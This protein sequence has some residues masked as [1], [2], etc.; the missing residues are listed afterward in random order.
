M[1]LRSNQLPT[2][3]RSPGLDAVDNPPATFRY[4]SIK[5]SL[6][7]SSLSFLPSVVSPSTE[8]PREVCESVRHPSSSDVHLTP[9]I[10]ALSTPAS[11]S[12]GEPSWPSAHPVTSLLCSKGWLEGISSSSRLQAPDS[13]ENSE[14]IAVLK[15]RPQHPQKQPKFILIFSL[16]VSSMVSDTPRQSKRITLSPTTGITGGGTTPGA[17]G[18]GAGAGGGVVGL[19]PGAG[20][21]ATTG[22]GFCPGAGVG[23]G[24]GRG[25]FFPGMVMMT[26][27]G[28]GVGAGVGAGG[29]F[30]TTG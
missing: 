28:A 10:C 30:T 15:V 6:R 24:P 23:A 14:D 16:G 4:T 21:V 18:P 20:G 29:G 5:S 2:P 7:G 11:R 3:L 13:E 17:V 22:G 26:G 8:G 19:A 1:H 27:C 25:G 9:A 12:A